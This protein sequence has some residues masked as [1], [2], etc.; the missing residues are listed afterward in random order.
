M[1]KRDCNYGN[2]IVALL[3]TAAYSHRESEQVG[4]CIL[5]LLLME[6]E[7]WASKATAKWKIAHPFFAGSVR[8]HESWRAAVTTDGPWLRK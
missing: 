6:L 8:D 3:I 4:E 5:F 2:L 7:K 1:Q